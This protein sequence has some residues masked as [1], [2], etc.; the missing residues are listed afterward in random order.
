MTEVGVAVITYKRQ[1]SLHRALASIRRHC[2]PSL[3]IVVCDDEGSNQTKDISQDFNSHYITGPNG[4]V[5]WNKNR[6]LYFLRHSIGAK[7]YLIVEDD[8]EVTDDGW[9]QAWS[10]AIDK[11]GHINFAHPVTIMSNPAFLKSGAGT[12]EDPFATTMLTGQCTGGSA[13]SLDG[14]G[15]LSNKFKGYG[16]GHVEWT[17]R[18]IDAGHGGGYRE[19]GNYYFYGINFGI[20]DHMLPTNKDSSALDANAKVLTELRSLKDRYSEPWLNDQERAT[21]LQ[22][23]QKA[24]D[25]MASVQS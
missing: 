13:A 18:C 2:S 1:A 5:C 25:Q 21:F 4:G 12:P 3:P 15:Y 16:H 9:I 7:R 10:N 20:I 22:E 6:G 23:Q 24:T 14:A 11:A 19:G 8:C 17:L